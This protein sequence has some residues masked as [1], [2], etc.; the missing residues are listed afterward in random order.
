MRKGRFIFRPKSCAWIDA[1]TATAKSA[2]V[3]RLAVSMPPSAKL[4]LSARRT[5]ERSLLARASLVSFS[6]TRRFIVSVLLAVLLTRASPAVGPSDNLDFAAG[7][8]KE[9]EGEGFYLTNA[10]QKAPGLGF[11]VCS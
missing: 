8:L 6:M 2:P 7:T 5:S 3:S 1:P 4:D 9:G 10:S 11:S